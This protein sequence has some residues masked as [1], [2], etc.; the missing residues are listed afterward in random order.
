MYLKKLSNKVI[1]LILKKITTHLCFNK[2]K[3]KHNEIKEI[4]TL[5]NIYKE[6]SKYK[7][8]N[9]DLGFF[10]LILTIRI[11]ERIIKRN[12]LKRII[13]DILIIKIT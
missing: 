9:L 2:Y 1:Y 13:I 3:I 6:K 12:K 4:K 7:K 11:K 10:Q 5:I 8:K